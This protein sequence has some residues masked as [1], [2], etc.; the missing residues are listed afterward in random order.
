MI[1]TIDLAVRT[2]LESCSL[3]TSVCA[4]FP[5]NKDN[6]LE[7]MD[8]LPNDCTEVSWLP[9]PRLIE[10]LESSS[11]VLLVFQVKKKRSAKIIPN[12]NEPVPRCFFT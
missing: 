10:Y 3:L 8:D 5:L 11:Q 2:P 12:N 1:L 9:L 4:A 6:V 7:L